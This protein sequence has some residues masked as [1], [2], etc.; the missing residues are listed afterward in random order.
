MGQDNPNDGFTT[1]RVYKSSRDEF[2]RRRR[3]DELMADVVD[4]ELSEW[5]HTLSLEEV[6]ERLSE[7]VYGR[8]DVAA[9]VAEPLPSYELADQ[10]ALT[11]YARGA[12]MEETLNVFDP[13][14]RVSPLN[15][16]DTVIRLAPVTGTCGGPPAG[17]SRTHTTLYRSPDIL[18]LE[19]LGA[20]EGAE[21][22]RKQLREAREVG[23]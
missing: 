22:L 1:I 6:I 15:D 17:D 13:V 14:E 2:D 7:D 12:E 10:L 23:Q 21:R 19:A 9:I 5:V 3:D 20:K 16:S 18:G 11:V 8:E 4:R